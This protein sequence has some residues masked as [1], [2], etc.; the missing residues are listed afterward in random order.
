MKNEYKVQYMTKDA[1]IAYAGGALIVPI[2]TEI[3]T[4][5][6]AEEAVAAVQAKYPEMVVNEYPQTLAEIEA[7]EKRWAEERRIKAEKEA[8]AKARKVA[9]DLANGITPEKRKAINNLKRH[10]GAIRHLEAEI[11]RLKEELEIEKRIVERK[12]AEIERM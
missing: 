8:A 1:Y 10:E 4:A 9:R 12:K 5:E 3:V 2:Q 7:K 6:T 11:E